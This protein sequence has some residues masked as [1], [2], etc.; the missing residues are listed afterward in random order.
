MA[1]KSPRNSDSITNPAAP[2]AALPYRIYLRISDVSAGRRDGIFDLVVTTNRAEASPAAV[3]G[4]A[5]SW[6]RNNEHQ[7]NERVSAERLSAHQKSFPII[8][9]HRALRGGLDRL[10]D[11]RTAAEGEL[12]SMPA[13]LSG[14]AAHIRFSTE[15]SLTVEEVAD[16]R[17]DEYATTRQGVINRVK[18]ATTA[19]SDRRDEV[20]ETVADVLTNFEA[21]IGRVERLRHFHNRRAAAYARAYLRRHVRNAGTIGNHILATHAEIRPIAWIQEPCPWLNLPFE[22]EELHPEAAA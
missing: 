7:F 15:K 16:R 22:T 9:R 5:T 3:D 19:V 4:P 20:A 17:R 1:N 8:E 11:A 14:E 21:L 18:A 13:E 6:L 10:I 12:A 2:L